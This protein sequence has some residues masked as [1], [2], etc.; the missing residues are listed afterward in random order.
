MNDYSRSFIKDH[1]GR[2]LDRRPGLLSSG[3]I[4]FYVSAALL[5]STILEICGVWEK[6]ARLLF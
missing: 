6:V 5:A 4:Y 2:L 1:L 3:D